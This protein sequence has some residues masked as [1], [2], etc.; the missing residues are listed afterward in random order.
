MATTL[1]LKEKTLHHLHTHFRLNEVHVLPLKPPGVNIG[2]SGKEDAL[3]TK[4]KCG[5]GGRRYSLHNIKARGS[6]GEV[7]RTWTPL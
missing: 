2:V 4:N 6:E 1:R 7:G 5:G 3:G